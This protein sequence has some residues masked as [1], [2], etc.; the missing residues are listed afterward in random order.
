MKLRQGAIVLVV[1]AEDSWPHGPVFESPHCRD[2]LASTIHLDQKHAT[3][4][5]DRKDNLAL[6]HVL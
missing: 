2:N 4:I 5:L 1:K 6:L 3:I